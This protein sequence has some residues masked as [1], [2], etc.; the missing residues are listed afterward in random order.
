MAVRFPSNWLFEDYAENSD[1]EELCVNNTRFN[2]W[3]AVLKAFPRLVVVRTSARDF[4][5]M[6]L[7]ASTEL[8]CLKE[9]VFDEWP[10]NNHKLRVAQ[11][12]RF[13]HPS[14][15]IH[16]HL[17]CELYHQNIQKGSFMPPRFTTVQLKSYH[18]QNIQNTQIKQTTRRLFDVM[19]LIVILRATI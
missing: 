11:L 7:V 5:S 9:V 16:V 14:E 17:P 8:A 6:L 10:Q 4:A 13:I 1:L 19:S 12:G 3:A 18:R 2:D 15:R